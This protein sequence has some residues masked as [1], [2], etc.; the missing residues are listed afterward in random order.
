MESYGWTRCV[1]ATLKPVILPRVE[2]TFQ[3]PN[4]LC[5]LWYLTCWV[6]WEESPPY[7]LR[8][9]LEVVGRKRPY[10]VLGTSNVSPTL[11]G[12]LS[13][14]HASFLI[15]FCCCCSQLEE[16]RPKTRARS[17]RSALLPP[18]SFESLDVQSNLC[19][20]SPSLRACSRWKT[21][22]TE[23]EARSGY[24][25]SK[26]SLGRGHTASGTRQVPRT[27]LEARHPVAPPANQQ[28]LLCKA[29]SHA[30][31]SQQKCHFLPLSLSLISIVHLIKKMSE[32][33]KLKIGKRIIFF[34]M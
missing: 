29:E 24:V 23:P 6:F 5:L 7:Q 19:S 8:L 12:L 15:V 20:W 2:Q 34:F 9:G 25:E 10:C 26:G 33:E 27:T 1:P 18:W 32:D 22:D 21:G 30:L 13:L 3:R 17:H 16:L 14:I 11:E 4:T 28:K 31:N